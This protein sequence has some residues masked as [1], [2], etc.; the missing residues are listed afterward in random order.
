MKNS[1]GN[2]IVRR[3]YPQLTHGIIVAPSRP[4]AAALM[5]VDK[6]GGFVRKRRPRPA[7]VD[8]LL[9]VFFGSFG[10]G[11][12]FTSVLKSLREQ[13]PSARIDALVSR[14]VGAI[15][16]GSPYLSSVVVTEMPS[17]KAY[18]GKIPGLVRLMRGF[19]TQYDAA[20]CLRQTV[21][22]GILPLVLS[23]VSRYNI[24]FSTGGFSF[25]LDEVVPWRPGVHEAQH[26]LDAIRAI[27]PDCETGAQELFYDAAA[28]QGA[29]DSKLRAMG[30]SDDTELIVVHPGSK[31]MRRSLSVER[32]R[33][34][35]T[36]L[37]ETTSATVLV[38]GIREEREFYELIGTRHPRV[39]PTLGMF[40]IPELTELIKR[41]AGVVTV[42]TFVSHLAGYAGVPALA[43]W[44]GVTD[45][46]QWRPMGKNV[47]VATVAP[48]CAPCFKWC[49]DPICMHHDPGAVV[50]IV[51]PSGA[52]AGLQ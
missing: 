51:G 35:L 9:L 47:K 48:P 25:C 33:E 6:V 16:E 17:G 34:V 1:A 32:W 50:H 30:I 21:D 39:I 43:Y 7:R 20:V 41:S 52:P 38:T 29:V 10:D 11:L 12:M 23:R 15:L 4:L 2:R 22:N 45:V 49:E 18:P 14:D 3:K 28:T 36:N 24:G 8:K 26:M 5:L 46:R 27:C 31:V 44:T 13:L 40:S 42:E 19:R 37:T